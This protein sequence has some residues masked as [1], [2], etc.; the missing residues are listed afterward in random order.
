MN[1]YKKAK[2]S[3]RPFTV[4]MDIDDAWDLVIDAREQIVREF[5]SKGR[6]KGS[7]MSWSVIPISRMT[8]IWQDFSQRGIVNDERGLEA[9]ADQII[10]ILARLRA[11]TDLSGHSQV[12]P[13]EIMEEYGYRLT[14]QNES[15]FYDYFLET[16]YG[17]P[18]S[19]YGL[20]PLWK[21]AFQLTSAS[22]AEEKLVIITQMLDV[23]HQ[24]GDLAALFVEGGSSA[25]SQLGG[26]LEEKDAEKET[27]EANTMRWYKRAQ[28]YPYSL[29]ETIV[30][31]KERGLPVDTMSY[32]ELK[33][34][35][36]L[37][38]NGFIKKVVKENNQGKYSAYV[39]N[40]EK[41]QQMGWGENLGLD[42]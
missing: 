39:I 22:T 35:K 20:N 42:I 15:D 32:Y 6:K 38:K 12:S 14:K 36:E 1:W 26:M 34:A 13:E 27:I 16:P 9:I 28:D 24:R 5:F 29:L 25:M 11:A 19:D 31:Q 40:P 30:M 2:I 21:L 41:F 3:K 23:V 8:K 33:E 37:E 4:A 7:M 17:T 10:H 18:I